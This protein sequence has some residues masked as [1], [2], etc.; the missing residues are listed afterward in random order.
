MNN[1]QLLLHYELERLAEL[2]NKKWTIDFSRG[3]EYRFP[4]QGTM[5]EWNYQILPSIEAF[6]Q[7]INTLL[8]YLSDTT[9]EDITK[10][11]QGIFSIIGDLTIVNGSFDEKNNTI[12]IQKFELLK[13]EISK[14]ENL[15]IFL[16]TE[17]GGYDESDFE[18]VLNYISQT[19]GFLPEFYLKEF[20]KIENVL[21]RNDYLSKLVHAYNR[22]VEGTY[23]ASLLAEV[24]NFFLH[25][26]EQKINQK[27][28]EL[29]SKEAE[30]KNKEDET[31]IR[32]ENAKNETTI[33]EFRKKADDLRIYIFLLNGLISALFISIILFFFQKYYCPPVGKTEIIYSIT[34]VIAI[35][36]FLAFL[37]KEKN[38]LSNQYHNYMKCH[39][40][41]VAL[42]TYLL[43]I[44]KTK[45]E[46]LKIRLAE[47]YFT[48]YTQDNKD[49]N[50]NAINSDALNQ[51]VSLLKDI[52]KK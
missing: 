29:K 46:D 45:S 26:I 19:M 14:F 37:I 17:T 41:I 11:I 33:N 1:K 16:S 5:G 47:K 3:V 12:F 7:R 8:K 39:T 44:D 10:L 18:T 22:M 51:I 31:F 2:K 50:N 6:V 20:L 30:L 48:G 9:V 42:A 32:I 49:T 52:Q 28:T 35:S 23:E 36:S 21:K 25:N 13:I 43:D 40:E 24:N 34:L 4:S 38:T 27:E 15:Q